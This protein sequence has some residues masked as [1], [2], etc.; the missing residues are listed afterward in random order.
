MGEDWG[1]GGGSGREE[2]G[3]RERKR[4]MVAE[5]EKKRGKEKCVHAY[6]C[7]RVCVCVWCVGG[8]EIE[9]EQVS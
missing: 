8:W 3:G 5:S 9:K 1:G 7:I 2:D 4:G 6:V